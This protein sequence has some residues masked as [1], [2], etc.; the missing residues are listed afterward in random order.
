MLP[1]SRLNKCTLDLRSH[2]RTQTH[3]GDKDQRSGTGSGTVAAKVAS[4]GLGGSLQRRPH[5]SLI[6]KLV[7]QSLGSSVA[8]AG[9]CSPEK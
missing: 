6:T 3:T 8:N 1:P 4:S 7:A 2:I 5:D 9:P